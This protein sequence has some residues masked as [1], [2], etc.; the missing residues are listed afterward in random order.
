MSRLFPVL[1]VLSA[2]A[3]NAFGQKEAILYNFP[4]GN[5]QYPYAGFVTDKAG[6]LYS[7]AAGGTGLNSSGSVFEMIAPAKLGDAWQEVDLYDFDPQGTGGYSPIGGVIFDA[8]GNLYGTTKFGGTSGPNCPFGGCGTIFELSPP[9]NGGTAWTETNLYNFQYAQDG[10]LPRGSL[11][12]DKAGNLYGGNDSA[13]DPTCNCGVIFELSPPSV[14]GGPWTEKTLHAFTG[15]PNDGSGMWGNLTFDP[16]GNLYGVS[17]GGGTGNIGAAFQLT[18]TQG[19]NWRYNMF[20]SFTDATGD[21]PY[22][23]TYYNGNLYG[24]TDQGGGALGYGE[25]TVFEFSPSSNNSK[26]HITV[27]Y[28]FNQNSQDGTPLGTLT[29]DASGNLYGTASGFF[30]NSCGSA[31]KLAP[32][33]VKGGKWT[34]SDLHVFT[35]SSMDGCQP[36]SNVIFGKFGA[37]YGTTL[38][39]GTNMVGT[40]FGLLP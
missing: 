17:P 12:M 16:K 13:G 26:G 19:G 35:N 27:L 3:T 20:Y 7:T 36:R 38:N 22:A 21:T 9:T 18:P 32:P 14:P 10:G 31:F 11:V 40:V 28:I 25:G 15:T 34:K 23:L 6:N 30:E 2:L 1:I 4:G 37:L 8:A 39:G 29:V 24:T 33:Q 5:D